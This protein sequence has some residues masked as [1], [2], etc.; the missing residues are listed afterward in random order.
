MRNVLT[1]AGRELRTYL[2]S[3]ISYVMMGAYAFLGGWF[4]AIFFLPWYV[5]ASTGPSSPYGGGEVNLTEHLVGP[6]H[7]TMFVVLLLIT[8]I[9]TM[10]LLAEERKQRSIE[11]LVTSPVSSWEIV[12]GK[13]LGAVGLFAA[14][15]LTLL[16]Q[17]VLLYAYGTPD[18]GP[19]LLTYLGVFLLGGAFLAVGLAASAMTENQIIAAAL[20]FALLLVFWVIGEAGSASSAGGF[21][22]SGWAAQVSEYLS[23]FKHFEGLSKGVIDS[24]DVLYFGTFIGFFLFLAEQRVEALRWR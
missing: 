19:M 23:F 3:P 6:Y 13:F 16:Y 5:E 9:L 12:L 10:R 11:L 1:I 8:P 15:Q 14:M 4:F 24:R 21:G 18:T 20:S 2:T 17:P 7:Q 22:G